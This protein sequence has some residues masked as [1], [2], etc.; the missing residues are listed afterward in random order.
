VIRHTV[1]ST[2]VISLATLA[3]LAGSQ[4]ADAAGYWNVPSTFC[5]WCGCGFGG[6]YHAPLILGPPTCD[7]FAGPNEVRVPYAPNPYAC[8]PY[9]NGGCHA[10]APAVMTHG[11]R[12][13]AMPRHV[14]PTAAAPQEELPANEPR[15]ELFA[16]PVQ[17]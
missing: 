16:P 11:A 9:C 4:I 5:Q 15:G 8:A 10:S 17:P 2:I 13:P 12:P 6:G 3:V 1:R 14:T 7:C